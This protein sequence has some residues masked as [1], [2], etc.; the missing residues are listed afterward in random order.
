RGNRVGL[1][2]EFSITEKGE[3]LLSRATSL[4]IRI[5]TQKK[6]PIDN[7]LMNFRKGLLIA[8][9]PHCGKTTLI[10]NL[11]YQFKDEAVVICDE[12]K[13]I[14]SQEMNCDCIS[15]K[16]KAKAVQQAVRTL[17]PDIIICDEIGDYN[18][19][20]EILSAVNTGV[21]FICTAHSD[22]FH[23]LN[24]RP[25]IKLLLN[26]NVFDKVAFLSH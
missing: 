11:A 5:A 4:N 8:G 24:L 22:N 14:F 21:K 15:G 1:G 10:K 16:S 2:G 23:E 12:R 18:E 9:K 3:Y 7:E 13:E 25:N 19:A 26:A 17:N 20:N 6:Y